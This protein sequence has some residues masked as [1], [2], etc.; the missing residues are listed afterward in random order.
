MFVISTVHI[1]YFKVYNQL[2]K[3]FRKMYKIKEAKKQRIFI[4]QH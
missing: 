2:G 3:K 1:L 4:I